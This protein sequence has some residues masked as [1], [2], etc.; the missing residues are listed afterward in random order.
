MFG[1]LESLYYFIYVGAITF[2]LYP[3]LN[4]KPKIWELIIYFPIYIF[5]HFFIFY[6]MNIDFENIFIQTVFVVLID[7]IMI[8]LLNRKIELY[9]LFYITLFY[10]LYNVMTV[11]IA[12]ILNDFVQMFSLYIYNLLLTILSGLMSIGIFWLLKKMDVIA[13]KHVVKNNSLLFIVLNISVQFI[14][15]ILQ[16]LNGTYSHIS[17]ILV[18]FVGL[19]LTL[20]YTLNKAFLLAEQ[21]TQDLFMSTV[22]Q[23]IEQ[24]M[25]Q[26]EQDEKRIRKIKHDMKNH[27]LVIKELNDID[28]VHE[29]V[30]GIDSHFDNIGIINQKLSGNV[31]IDAILNSKKLQYPQV[32]INYDIDVSDMNI[33]SIDL[34]TLLFNLIDN[35]CSA[36]NKMN[37]YVDLKME[38][39]APHLLIVI[40]NSKEGDIDFVS[41]KG[42]GHGYGMMIIHDIVDKY[43][44]HIEYK[45]LEKEVLMTIVLIVDS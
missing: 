28:K 1:L 11:F 12:S 27:L 18:V 8:S 2:C 43:H 9:I 30:L 34:C 25:I 4:R 7:F 38:Y 35:A 15:F 22:Y 37:G 19:W 10:N 31:Y 44:G 24:Y 5:I 42:K 14:Y 23:N 32:S 33:E 20:L 29:Y 26:Y 13:S 3:Y 40:K 17:I 36:A 41:K 6:K 39:V 21:R 16:S 45:I